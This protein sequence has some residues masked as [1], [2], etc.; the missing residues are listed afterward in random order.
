MV[1]EHRPTN[2]MIQS[3]AVPDAGMKSKATTIWLNNG[4]CLMKW[5]NTRITGWIFFFVG[6]V[7]IWRSVESY[8]VTLIKNVNHVEIC[9]DLAL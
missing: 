5:Y 9:D 3:C 2:I 8:Y 4:H 1:Y 6:V 7:I